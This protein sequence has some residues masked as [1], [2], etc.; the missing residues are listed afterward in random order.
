MYCSVVKIPSYSELCDTLTFSKLLR[1]IDYFSFPKFS[2]PYPIEDVKRCE[3]GI[4]ICSKSSQDVKQFS[5]SFLSYIFNE[6]ELSVLDVGEFYGIKMLEDKGAKY[7][8]FGNSSGGSWTGTY[9]SF[10]VQRANEKVK[11]V[12]ISI[13]SCLGGYTVLIVAIEDE[14]RSHNSLQLNLDR[15][16]RNSGNGQIEILHDGKI[17]VANIGA[18]PNREVISFIQDKCAQL[19]IVDGRLILGKI[20]N[21]K[22]CF[23]QIDAVQS[24]IKN[25]ITY[26]ILRDD[27]RNMK[28]NKKKG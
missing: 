1:H 3:E 4:F 21:T 14:Y 19:P 7:T 13:M 18:F 17:S 23:D 12:N 15:C 8:S 20:D 24:L 10:L 27:F 2:Y 5:I 16:V 22:P 6:I 9:R 28:T 26:G 25:L 11:L